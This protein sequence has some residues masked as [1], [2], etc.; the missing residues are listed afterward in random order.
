VAWYEINKFNP[1]A[2]AVSLITT[3]SNGHD[4]Y[5]VPQNNARAVVN[6]AA[7]I[8]VGRIGEGL[9]IAE[10]GITVLGSYGKYLELGEELGART[11]NIPDAI[12]KTMTEEQRWAAN[13][14]FLNRTITRG[15]R[16]VLSNSAFE[17][18]TGTYFYRECN[19]Y[20]QRDIRQRPMVWH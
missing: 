11:F 19:I 12:W 18:K 13:V 10:E 9:I 14:R 15:D 7:V 6:L 4:Y 3:I 16:I 17:A 1:L 8:P 2:A 20:F 5:G